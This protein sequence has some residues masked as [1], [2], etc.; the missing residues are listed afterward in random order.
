MLGCLSEVHR[1]NFLSDGSEQRM[2][3]LGARRGES[4]RNYNKYL[5]SVLV[6]TESGGLLR[7]D[8]SEEV[9]TALLVSFCSPVDLEILFEKPCCDIQ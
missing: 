8:E 5:P 3:I 2:M 7:K 1:L 9:T 6:P 4:S